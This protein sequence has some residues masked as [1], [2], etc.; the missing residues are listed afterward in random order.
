MKSHTLLKNI[1]KTASAKEIAQSM[2]LSISTI[3]KW[4][5]SPSRGN[6]S[7]IRNPLDRTAL[8]HKVTGDKRIIN[9]ICA[10][11]KRLLHQ[12]PKNGKEERYTSACHQSR[13]QSICRT[14]GCRSPCC[15]RQ[16]NHKRGVRKYPTNMGN[17]KEHDRRVRPPLRGRKFPEA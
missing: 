14:F 2:K 6:A 1:L 16:P 15:W 10:A 3:Y 7:G 5:E 12:E 4:A 13:S 11:S 17:I 8:L 9:W